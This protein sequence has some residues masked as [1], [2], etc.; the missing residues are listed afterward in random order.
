MTIVA[1]SEGHI[2]ERHCKSLNDDKHGIGI[3]EDIHY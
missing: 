2:A 1:G 3:F